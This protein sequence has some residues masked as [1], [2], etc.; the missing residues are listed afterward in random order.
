[1]SASEPVTVALDHNFPTPLLVLL[2]DAMPEVRLV[3]IR[4]IDSRLAEFDDDAMIVALHQLQYGCLVITDRM[5]HDPVTLVAIEQTRFTLGVVE[6]VG[7]DPIRAVGALLLD[8]LPALRKRAGHKPQIFRLRPRAPAPERPDRYLVQV[9]EH[10]DTS[11]EDLRSRHR[12]RPA[13]LNR[14]LL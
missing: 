6:G 7:D 13:E 9:A 2:G 5:L 1:V 11:P 8:L 3:A 12:R 10:R 4:D 14:P